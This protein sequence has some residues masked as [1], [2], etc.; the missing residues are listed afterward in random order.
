MP[1]R[2]DIIIIDNTTIV[3]RVSW[4]MTVATSGN[5]NEQPFHFGM[6]FFKMKKQGTGIF[7]YK[8]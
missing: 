4:Q 3:E 1:E 5:G 7:L 8:V 2:D 6:V